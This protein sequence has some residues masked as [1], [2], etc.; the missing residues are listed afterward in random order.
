MSI[1]REQIAITAKLARLQ[2]DQS[3]VGEITQRINAILS[4]VDEMQAVDTSSVVPMANALDA[5]QTLR[6]DA[7]SE[8]VEQNKKIDRRD[9]FQAIAPATD[10]GLYLVPKVIE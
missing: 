8:P 9:Q 10:D 4:L 5:V 2:I 3:D 6:A 1:T 7:V